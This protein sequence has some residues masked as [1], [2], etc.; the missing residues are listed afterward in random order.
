MSLLEKLAINKKITAIF[1]DGTQR[2][3]LGITSVVDLLNGTNRVPVDVA[4]VQRAS[5][6]LTNLAE[7]AGRTVQ[8]VDHCARLQSATGA[9]HT[10]RRCHDGGRP[11]VKG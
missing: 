4:P 10:R 1:A 2:M 8:T 6:L 5:R 7:S 11:G 9:Q 3:S